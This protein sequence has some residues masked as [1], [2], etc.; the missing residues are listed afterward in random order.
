MF[1]VYDDIELYIPLYCVGSKT[2]AIFFA[3]RCAVIH[4][5]DTPICHF[6][7]LSRGKS[8]QTVID[9]TTVLRCKAI[10]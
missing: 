1:C 2:F 10:I 7:G 9:Q 8:G 6:S 4:L 5:P 3:W